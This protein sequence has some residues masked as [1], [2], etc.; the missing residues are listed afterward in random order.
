MG[1][2]IRV[3]HVDDEP[4]FAEMVAGHLERIGQFAVTTATAPAE[5]LDLL[6]ANGF[7][8]IVSDYDLPDTDGIELLE[9][10]R[11]RHPTLPFI[12]FTGKGSEAIASRAI[13][14]GVTDYMRKET[15]TDQY[16]ILAKRIEIAVEAARSRRA[17]TERTRRLETLIETLPGVVYRCWMDRDWTMDR[18]DGE[19]E[20]ITGYSVDEIE[21][22]T[23]SYGEDIIHPDDRESIWETVTAA[24]AAGE[25]YEVTYRILTKGGVVTRVWECGRGV[26]MDHLDDRMA[27]LD[28]AGDP[29]HMLEGFITD[30]PDRITPERELR[31]SRA[32]YRALCEQSP[33]MVIVHDEAGTITEVNASAV[34]KLGYDRETL[35]GR[36]IWDVDRTVDLDTV[37][38]FWSKLDEETPMFD[39]EFV[40]KDGTSFPVEIHLRRIEVPENDEYLAI[41]RDVSSR[42]ERER[43]LQAQSAELERQNERL[44]MF[45]DVLAHDIPNHLTM[46][47]GYLEMARESD[48]PEYLDR[49]ETVHRRIETLLDDMTTLLETGQPIESV[50]WVRLSTIANR[51]WRHCCPSEGAATLEVDRDGRVR[52]DEGRLRQLLENLFWNACDHADADVSVRVGMLEDGFYVADDGP[53]IPPAEREAVLEP[54]Y[55]LGGADHTGLGLTIVKGIADAH[56]WTV[57]IAESAV[58]GARFEFTAVD[59]EPGEGE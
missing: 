30:I 13:S 18:I 48:D 5:A 56:G 6:T 10:V 2:P 21:A 22:G 46:G 37:H 57:A 27:S 7:D 14:T 17:L 34:E 52:A 3:L 20:S 1:E 16:E 35:I 45:A 51:C 8:C 47:Q 39:G 58:G 19:V 38:E 4:G 53:G 12:L 29:D 43:T 59:A 26:E 49:V 55:S 31:R 24:V 25:T 9:A 33:D 54:G 36:K 32:R 28:A 44:E 23:V 40:R 11:E 41:V 42:R 15:G 50:D